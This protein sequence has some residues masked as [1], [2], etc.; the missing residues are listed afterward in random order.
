MLKKL[1]K[2]MTLRH[3]DDDS[4]I[5][6]FVIKEVRVIVVLEPAD[7]VIFN[8]RHVLQNILCYAF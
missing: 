7:L 5:R 6:A 4:F 8:C 1:K 3:D 2:M